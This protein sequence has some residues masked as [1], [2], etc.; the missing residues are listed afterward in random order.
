[1]VYRVELTFDGNMDV[2]DIKY[3]SAKSIVYTLFFGIYETSDINSMI[4]SLLPNE[5]K[6]KIII[7]DIR[8]RS[9]LTKKTTKRFL[10]KSI[11]IP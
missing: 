3:T 8:L 2:L 5:V 11:F 7:E 6:V 1:M 4:N 9:N 10:T